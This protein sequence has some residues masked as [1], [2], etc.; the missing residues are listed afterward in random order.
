[1][2]AVGAEQAVRIAGRRHWAAV[3][4]ASATLVLPAWQLTRNF[5]MTDRSGDTSAAVTFDGLFNAVPDRSELVHEDFLVDRMV[6]FKLL[7]EGA[8]GSR[9][10]DM[11]PRNVN[12]IEKRLADGFHVFGFQRSVRRLRFDGLNFS[13]APLAIWDRAAVRRP[14]APSSTARSSL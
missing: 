6:M 12:A 13:F 1:M 3:A 14:V 11:A 2:A 5:A 4:V 9:R 10:I 7:G 8:A